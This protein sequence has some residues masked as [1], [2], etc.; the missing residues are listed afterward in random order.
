MK[1]TFRD[2]IAAIL[3]VV[4]GVVMFAKLQSYNWWLIG[5]WRGALGVLAV[6]GLGILL[7]NIV[8]VVRMEDGAAVGEFALW[9]VA[10]A[11]TVVSLVVAT[12]QAEFIWSGIAIGVAWLAQL[13][14]HLLSSDDRTHHTY[15]P[16]R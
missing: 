2:V 5:S 12:T 13:S 3:A 15:I 1:T 8:E 11:V 9:A 7:T 16:A 10:A 6:L 4:G 14:R